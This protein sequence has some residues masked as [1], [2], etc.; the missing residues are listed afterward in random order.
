[1]NKLAI[2]TL[3]IV[4]TLFSCSN[5]TNNVTITKEEY[6]KLKGDTDR[7]SYPKTVYIINNP[8][9]S[10]KSFDVYLGTDGHEYQL[11]LESRVDDQWIHYPGCQ[12]CL[13]RDSLWKQN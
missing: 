8:R 5:N 11:H 6:S 4:N 12:K 13:K 2:I 10:A 1:M 9:V 3:I 7:L